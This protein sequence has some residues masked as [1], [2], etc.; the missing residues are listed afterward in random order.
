M[1]TGQSCLSEI[2]DSVQR[3]HVLSLRPFLMPCQH[4]NCRELPVYAYIFLKG[5]QKKKNI[6]LC[7]LYLQ[8]ALLW[9]TSLGYGGAEMRIWSSLPRTGKWICSKLKRRT[10]NSWRLFFSI[11]MSYLWSRPREGMTGQHSKGWDQC[12]VTALHMHEVW[13][14][15]ESM[16]WKTLNTQDLVGLV[17]ACRYICEHMYVHMQLFNLSICDYH[18]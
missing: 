10:A 18:L 1:K 11:L 4:R 16:R 12:S 7:S 5:I 9:F 17:C 6:F 3:L 13:V 15:C 8:R 14:F 2:I